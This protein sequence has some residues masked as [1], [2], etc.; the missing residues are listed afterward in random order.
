MV[1]CFRCL[2]FQLDLGLM[3]S[4][5]RKLRQIPED[6]ITSINRLHGK[7]ICVDRTP[8]NSSYRIGEH[9]PTSGDVMLQQVQDIVAAQGIHRW[10]LLFR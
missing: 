1:S 7:K 2:K 8:N 5:K 10:Y 3:G 9:G 4:R 6:S